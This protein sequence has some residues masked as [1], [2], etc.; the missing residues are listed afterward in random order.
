[1][2]AL[3]KTLKS[4]SAQF[5]IDGDFIYA[6]PYGSGHINDTFLMTMHQAGISVRYIVQRINH[7]IF[8]NPPKLMENIQRVTTH[9]RFKLIEDG[10]KDVSRR[11]LTLSMTKNGHSFYLDQDGQ[12][13]RIY[14]FI[15]NAR[16]YDSV[17]TP[18]QAYQAAKA[19]GNFQ[20]LLTDLTGPA[21]HETIPDF[22]HTP[23]RF[24]ALE[25][26]IE[27]DACNR[28]LSVSKEIEF[29]LRHREMTSHLINLNETGELPSRITHNDTKLNNVML[30]DITGEGI[31][32][33]DLDTLMPG[34]SLYDFGDLVRTSTSL[35]LEDEKDLSKVYLQKSMFESL[36]TGY[37]ESM[38]N[39]LSKSE[40][41]LLPFA[42]KLI[43]FEIGTRF[44]TDYLN[45][46]I[47]FK[48]HRKD[49]N[50]DRCR[51][52]FKL[53]ESI[54]SQEEELN[55]VIESLL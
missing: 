54:K 48:T 36:A 19:F 45:G 18:E 5:E 37:L 33:I 40:K 44:L 39:K 15:E 8:K 3:L 32:I 4:V 55:Q 1:M 25:L 38:G 17:Q 21:L 16:T 24:K 42:G 29:A 10:F 23:K 47:Y 41:F 35:S 9:L 31:C 53:V 52:Q 50:V 30:D 46:D 34:F 6:E 28:A 14:L 51:T 20:A 49:H 13:W 27:K 2:S 11:V 22:H 12:Y 7:K 26:A 43:S